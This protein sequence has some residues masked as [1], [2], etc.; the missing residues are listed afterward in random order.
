MDN[1]FRGETHLQP[2]RLARRAPYVPEAFQEYRHRVDSSQPGTANVLT[3]EQRHP[4]RHREPDAGYVEVHGRP[5]PPRALDVSLEYA[6]KLDDYN[7]TV[8]GLT[9]G[10][11][12]RVH[13]R[14]ELRLEGDQVL[15][16]LRLRRLLHRRRPGGRRTTAAP[17]A[18]HR[19]PRPPQASTGMRTCRNN[20][21]A[22]GV[23]TSIPI[24][25][26]KLAFK[27][28]YDFE[29]NNGYADFTSQVFTR[30]RPASTTAT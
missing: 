2:L 23:G 24:I 12:E 28:Q 26:N 25:K 16:L 29:K 13:P 30:R 20:N 27:V 4:L 10:G 1:T 8:L 18:T 19:A 7:D 17:T 22:Y 9:E 3:D 14:R 11:G 6:Y 21:Y 15:R 5:H